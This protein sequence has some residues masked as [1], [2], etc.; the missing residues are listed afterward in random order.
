MILLDDFWGVHIVDQF[1][2]VIARWVTFLLDE[3]LQGFAPSKEPVI[4][5]RL[6]F[7]LLVS[8]HKVR[9]GSREVR[10]VRGRLSIGG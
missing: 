7:E 9:G 6:Y 5:N 4:D 10:T 2:S 3:V 1:P 8:L